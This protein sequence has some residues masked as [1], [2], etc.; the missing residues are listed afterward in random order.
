MRKHFTDWLLIAACFVLV[1]STLFV[2]VPVWLRHCVWTPLFV[3]MV[4]LGAFP[5]ARRLMPLPEK[6]LKP[7]HY[8]CAAQLI[9]ALVFAYCLMFMLAG[10][11]NRPP[12][13]WSYIAGGLF[14]ITCFLCLGIPHLNLYP[15]SLTAVLREGLFRHTSLSAVLCAMFDRMGLFSVTAVALCAGVAL[16]LCS[17]AED[18]G[19]SALR[20]H[21]WRFLLWI[22]NALLMIPLGGVLIAGLVAVEAELRVGHSLGIALSLT[23]LAIGVATLFF[24]AARFAVIPLTLV[25]LALQRKAL[26]AAW[27]PV[28]AAFIR[29]RA[30]RRAR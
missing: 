16:L 24:P 13:I 30:H 25:G 11:G 26:Y 7:E 14:L 4:S 29:R 19:E 28:R 15:V 3:R 10:N 9:L 17:P 6:G 22:T 1:A 12:Y 27:L 2:Y 5:A 20:A 21:V 23:C 18:T 8:A